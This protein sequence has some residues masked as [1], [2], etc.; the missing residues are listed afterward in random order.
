MRVHPWVRVGLQLVTIALISVLLGEV[1]LRLAHPYVPVPTV[2]TGTYQDF[3][4]R[5]FAPSLGGFTLNSKGFKDLEYEEEKP[6]GM[7]RILGIGDSFA[8]SVVPYQDNFLT[9]LEVA[10]QASHGQVEVINM[11]VPNMGAADYYKMLTKEGA[12]LD[13]DLVL[14]CLYLGNDL[15]SV[16]RGKATRSYVVALLRYAFTQWTKVEGRSL[17]RKTGRAYD[18]LRPSLKKNV[19]QRLLGRKL[20][21]FNVENPSYQATWP[22]VVEYLEKIQRFC[23]A[24]EIG[25]IVAIL[26]DELQVDEEVREEILAARPAL[27]KMVFD[28]ELPNRFVHQELERLEIESIDLLPSMVEA[29]KTEK[30]YKPRDTHWNLLGNRIA[31]REIHRQLT[32]RSMF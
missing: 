7:Y 13:P 14:L 10:L 3:R 20:R 27:R 4:S 12:H 31:A 17:G 26:P 19:Y 15:T 28:F 2:R 5:P 1:A 11:G 24:R 32:E 22:Q 8:F 18:D 9:R 23:A 21:L 16:H 30:L 29:A 25:L 6:V